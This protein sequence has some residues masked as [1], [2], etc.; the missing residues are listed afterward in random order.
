M[1]AVQV[2]SPERA[3]E[4]ADPECRICDGKGWK[5]S[6]TQIIRF[7]RVNAYWTCRAPNCVRRH[8]D[9]LPVIRYGVK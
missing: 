9:E 1:M 8:F 5:I 3:T 2:I 4:L 6:N 7:R